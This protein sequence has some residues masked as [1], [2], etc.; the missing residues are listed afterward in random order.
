MRPSSTT[1]ATAAG[2]RG[3]EVR[4]ALVAASTALLVHALV[5]YVTQVPAI[6]LAWLALLSLALRRSA[7]RRR[8]RANS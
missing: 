5:E 1:V 8:Q 4:F 2:R 7:T 3:A 6:W